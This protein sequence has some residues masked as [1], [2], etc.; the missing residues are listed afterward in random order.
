MGTV[1]GRLLF[2]AAL[3]IFLNKTGRLVFLEPLDC[4]FEEVEEV[5]FL[6]ILFWCAEA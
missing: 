1:R 3:I 2:S 5:S 6:W 4:F